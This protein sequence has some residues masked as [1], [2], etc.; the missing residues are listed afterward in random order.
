MTTLLGKHILLGVTGGIAAYKTPYLVRQCKALGADVRVI[1]TKNAKQFVTATTLQAVSGHPIHDDLFDPAQE[2]AMGHIDLARWADYVLIAPTT[3]DCLARLAHGHADD[4]LTTVC[5]AT[6]API[7]LVPAM[8]R[9]MWEN[10][11]TLANIALLQKRQCHVLP[12]G[13]GE[14]ACGEMGEGRMLEPEE[15]IEHL[16]SLILPGPLQDKKI[17]ITAGPTHEM[18][19][20]VRFIGNPSTGKMGYAIANAAMNMGADVTLIS[21]PTTLASP[22]G[23]QLIQA[24]TA[25]EMYDAVMQNI[26]HQDIF[27]A[28]AA[29]S[30]YRP[31]TQSLQKIKKSNEQLHITLI[32]N[33]DILKEVAQLPNRPFCVGFAAE[34]EN[35]IENAKAKLINKKLDMIC[36]NDVSDQA[37][38]FGSD[39]NA[40][41]V[42]T[43]TQECHLPKQSK[44]TLA[45]KLLTLMSDIISS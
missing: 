5:L 30:D 28:T 29:V 44:H 12:V 9:V 1:L 27:I 45:K 23:I 43:P 33:P 15:I 26:P 22:Q 2:A 3:A 7:I 8:N 39:E 36:V 17:L 34:T 10:P 37:I 4:L 20:P 13:M 41:T 40:L 11:A 35:T 16:T 42:L 25:N 19:D 18:I 38:G 14:Q 31:Q 21:G 6:E 24:T 32:P